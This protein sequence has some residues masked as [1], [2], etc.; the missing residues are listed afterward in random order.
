MKVIDLEE[1]SL[2][3]VPSSSVNYLHHPVPSDTKEL[4]KETVTK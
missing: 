1:F 2:C 3:H 4:K